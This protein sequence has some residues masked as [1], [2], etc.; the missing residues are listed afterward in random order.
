MQDVTVPL[1][2]GRAVLYNYNFFVFQHMIV[3]LLRNR[4]LD[5]LMYLM[6]EILMLYVAAL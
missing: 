1:S 4:V 5:G 2:S 3:M 6:P